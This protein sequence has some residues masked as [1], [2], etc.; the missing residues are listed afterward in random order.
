MSSFQEFRKDLQGLRALAFPSLSG[1]QQ[2]CRDPH[3]HT[4]REKMPAVR[5]SIPKTD[6]WSSLDIFVGLH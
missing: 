4:H 3:T 5:P 6:S 1:K 2:S